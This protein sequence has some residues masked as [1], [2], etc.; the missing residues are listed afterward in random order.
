MAADYALEPV[1]ALDTAA[2]DAVRRIYEDG[3][4]A[5]LR[6]DFASLT[7]RREPD[8]TA[9][10]LVRG[11][12]PCGFV[13]LRRL[14]ATGWTYLR[15]FVIE[16]RLRG[17]GLGGTM[18][19]QLVARLR[20]DGAVLLVFD[21]EDPDEP[22]CGPVQ[23][24]VRSARVGF[25]QRHGAVVLPVRGYRTPHGNADDDGWAPM[26]LMAAPV[27]AGRPAPGAGQAR[28]IV[29]AVYQYR[30]RLDPGHPQIAA[31]EVAAPEGS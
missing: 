30:W 25:Y 21:V 28:A 22:G 6:A 8:E 24:R 2:V 12:Q 29:S 14:G 11:R 19:D 3:F 26:L 20:A 16:Q 4:P 13:M 17:R 5:R 7:D 18:W 31:T 1:E 9:L 15:Y 23:A 27:A 10:A